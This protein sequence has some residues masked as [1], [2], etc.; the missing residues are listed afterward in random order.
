MT[1]D[2]KESDGFQWTEELLLKFIRVYHSGC[3]DEPPY[4][5]AKKVSQKISIFKSMHPEGYA[6]G[7]RWTDEL[8]LKFYSVATLGS[9]SAPYVGLKKAESKLSVFKEQPI[10]LPKYS[11]LKLQLS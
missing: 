9:H 1:K 6:D 8:V 4:H 7:F 3:A 10:N 2:K 5:G 11:Q